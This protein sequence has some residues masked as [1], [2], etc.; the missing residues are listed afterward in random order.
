MVLEWVL[1]LSSVFIRIFKN[2]K[3]SDKRRE[4]GLKGKAFLPGCC[5][6]ECQMACGRHPWAICAAQDD[7]RFTHQAL[8][9]LLIRVRVYPRRA[10]S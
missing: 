7:G 6:L 3:I 10:G 8:P 1:F 5:H 4:R 9:R 2:F